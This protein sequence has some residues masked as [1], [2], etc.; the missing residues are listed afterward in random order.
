MEENKSHF[1]QAEDRCAMNESAMK[2][3]PAKLFVG[4]M[5]SI[6]NLMIMKK[7]IWCPPCC[8]RY[9]KVVLL[10]DSVDCWCLS[11]I[12]LWS[13]RIYNWTAIKEANIFLLDGVWHLGDYGSC[14]RYLDAIREYSSWC[15]YHD[16]EAIDRNPL[17]LSPARWK[18]DW[19]MLCLVIARQSNRNMDDLDGNSL[20]QYVYAYSG[21]AALKAV[22][23][24]L[25][26]CHEA[27][28]Q[29]SVEIWHC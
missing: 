12:A 6:G 23:M 19:F 11:L 9:Q 26:R 25:L 13:I 16:P 15:Y 20:D 17:L 24:K 18:Y 3:L 7:W 1:V 22:M 29:Q 21:S 14:A 2:C 28:V 5:N 10:V 27:D 4:Q 8:W